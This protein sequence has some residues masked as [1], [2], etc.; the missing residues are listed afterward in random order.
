[1]H[2]LGATFCAISP[3]FD[4]LPIV[5]TSNAPF[6]WQ[7]AMHAWYIGPYERSGMRHLTSSSSPALFHIRPESRTTTGIDA[8]MI[9]S[10]GTCRL[11]MPRSE[12]TIASDGRVAYAASM[13]ASIALRSASGRLLIFSYSAARPLFGLTPALASAS[14]CFEKTSLKK[15][16]STW[17]KRIGSEIFIIVDLR[18]SETIRPF[19]LQSVSSFSMYSRSALADMRDESISSPA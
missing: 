12:S 15:T 17:P 4:T 6:F 11:V 13:S 7:S 2:D 9:T 10:E 14:A 3:T 5:A 16:V 19:S 8:S 1:M 18:W